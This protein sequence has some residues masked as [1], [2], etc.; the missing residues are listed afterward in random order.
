MDLVCLILE[1]LC[2]VSDARLTDPTGIPAA[3]IPM[4]ELFVGLYMYM[5]MYMHMHMHMF[6]YMHMYKYM[7]MY[8]LIIFC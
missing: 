6:M 7:D 8:M 5:Y 4:L 1:V 3:C 2:E